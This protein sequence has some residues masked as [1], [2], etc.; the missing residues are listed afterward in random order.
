[1][2]TYKHHREIES[3]MSKMQGQEFRLEALTDF[4]D[5]AEDEIDRLFGG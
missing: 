3:E 5:D 1:M 2:Q 4:V